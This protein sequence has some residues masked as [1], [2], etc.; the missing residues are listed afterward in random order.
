MSSARNHQNK[1]SS[2]M[3]GDQP[4]FGRPRFASESPLA[5]VARFVETSWSGLSLSGMT[6]TTQRSSITI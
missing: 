3:I 5:I 1:T 2:H 6:A 4:D